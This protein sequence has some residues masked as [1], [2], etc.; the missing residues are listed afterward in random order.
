MTSSLLIEIDSL[1]VYFSDSLMKPINKINEKIL[2]SLTTFLGDKD[3]LSYTPLESK[4]LQILKVYTTDEFDDLLNYLFD[5]IKKN[6]LDMKARVN[7]EM[8]D[9]T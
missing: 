1:L 5:Q 6:I 3:P 7:A 8:G 4:L 9:I 2:K